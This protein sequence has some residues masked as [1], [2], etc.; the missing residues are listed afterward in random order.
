MWGK[1][2]G[3]CSKTV[4]TNNPLTGYDLEQG[5]KVSKC[6]LPHRESRKNKTYLTG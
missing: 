1:D 2:G 4:K 6:Y 3:L 5:L